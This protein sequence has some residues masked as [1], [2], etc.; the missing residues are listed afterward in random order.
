[1]STFVWPPKVLPAKV[2]WQYMSTS[3]LVASPFDQTTTILARPGDKWMASADFGP[4]FGEPRADLIAFLARLRQQYHNFLLPAHFYQK[5]GSWSAPNIMPGNGEF[6]TIGPWTGSGATLAIDS[7]MLRVTNSAATAGTARSGAITVQ[8][9][10]AYMLRVECVPGS[11][12]ATTGAGGYAVM[13]GTAPGGTDLSTSGPIAADGVYTT[14]AVTSGTV[15][16]ITVYCNTN[17]AGDFVFYDNAT[18]E[19]CIQTL[20]SQPL[21]DK[22]VLQSMVANQNGFLLKA[23]MLEVNQELKMVLHGLNSNSGGQG[24]V[25]ISPPLRSVVNTNAPVILGSPRGRFFLSEDP[26]KFDTQGFFES[27]FTLNFVEDVG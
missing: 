7:G 6:D 8:P 19:P 16:H 20:G 2:T 26:L 24:Q 23:D 5:R 14:I 11:A 18:L 13:I 25:R 1:M 22:L 21:G 12:D 4:V 17:T 9:T 3:K 27:Q 15:M 10:V